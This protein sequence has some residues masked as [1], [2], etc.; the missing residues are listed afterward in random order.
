MPG[1]SGAV[2]MSAAERSHAGTAIGAHDLH[3]VDASLLDSFETIQRCL[4][5]RRRHVL[6]L[7]AERVA[8]AVDELDVAETLIAYEVAGVEPAVTFLENVA[9]QLRLAGLLVGV[10]VEGRGVSDLGDQQADA[11]LADLVHELAGAEPHRLLTLG[12]ELDDGEGQRTEA[13]SLGQTKTVDEGD[14]G[15]AR[16]VELVDLF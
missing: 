5:F 10:A 3:A 8:D 14:V 2:E 13:R 16:A 4:D 12:I 9:Q 7:P 1:Q 11:A 6:A 15:F